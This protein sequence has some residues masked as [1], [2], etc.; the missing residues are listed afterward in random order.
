MEHGVEF[1]ISLHHSFCLLL[2]NLFSSVCCESYV[3]ALLL[4]SV[5][6]PISCYGRAYTG[7]SGEVN[8]VSVINVCLEPCV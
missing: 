4:V 8:I 6:G 5:R 1:V 7:P 3:V 2:V